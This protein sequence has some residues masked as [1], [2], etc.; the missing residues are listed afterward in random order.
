M[1]GAGRMD[2]QRFRITNICQVR[3]EFDMADQVLASFETTLNAEAKDRS[4]TVRE[5]L[6]RQF[7]LWMVGQARI[8]HPFDGRMILK[9]LCDAHCIL[10]MTLHTQRQRLQPL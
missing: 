1:C 7:M 4:K 2:D 6:F 10:A 8:R 9:E 5:V 3:E